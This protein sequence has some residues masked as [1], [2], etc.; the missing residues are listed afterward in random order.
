MTDAGYPR[1]GFAVARNDAERGVLMLESYAATS[2]ARGEATRFT[3]RNLPDPAAVRVRRDGAEHAALRVTGPD[4]VE[5]ETRTVAA[6]PRKSA[7]ARWPPAASASVSRG[8]SSSVSAVLLFGTGVAAVA[9][10]S[11]Q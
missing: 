3:V 11:F 7:S 9:A 1:M 4:S 8:N 2:S 6:L 10:D 5:I